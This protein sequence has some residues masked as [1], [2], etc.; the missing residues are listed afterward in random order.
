MTAVY[1]YVTDT[2]TIVDDTS[3]LLADVQTE[4]VTALG[5]NLDTNA[6]TP[7]GTLIAAEALARTNVMKNNADLSNVFNPN[8]S[9]GVYLDG[10]CALLGIS[11]GK[12]SYTTATNVLLTGGTTIANI[13]AGQRVETPDGDIFTISAAVTIPINGTA[14]ATIQSQAFGAIPLPLGN[15]TILDGTIG[16]GSA[17]ITGLTLITPGTITLT[18]PQLKTARNQ[19]LFTQGVGSSGAIQAAA[20]NVPGVTSALVIENNTGQFALPVKGIQFTLPS[21]MWVCV[22]GT[23][24][25]AALAQ[26]L[27]NA[28]GGGCPWDY[29]AAGMGTPVASPLGVMA[30]DPYTGVSYMVMS[31][32]PLMYDTYINYYSPSAD[33]RFYSD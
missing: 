16:W 20:M 14:M 7:Q 13:T 19:E 25:Q 6:A 22:S 12:N 29:G 31:T 5:P 28:H 11:R 33:Q 17:T 9:Y 24:N 21:A 2:G 30:T 26:A 8:L 27:Y 10:I 18:D 32:T 15:L 1:N 4:F 3:T 23:P